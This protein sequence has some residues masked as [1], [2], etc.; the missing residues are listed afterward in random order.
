[1]RIVVPVLLHNQRLAVGADAFEG[2]VGGTNYYWGLEKTIPSAKAFND[3]F[4]AVNERAIPTDYGAYAY[5][6]V[7]SLLQ[8]M[9][10]AGGTDTD[11]VIAALE[12][13]KYD[14]GKGAQSYRKCDHQSIQ[15]VLVLEFEEKGR[16]GQ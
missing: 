2:I 10:V 12:G 15:S 7:K 6:A 13:L 3:A 14:T 1:M 8:A 4:R 5:T 9:T 16:Y 11:K